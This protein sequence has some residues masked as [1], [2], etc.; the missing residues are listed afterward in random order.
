VVAA[1]ASGGGGGGSSS[2]SSSNN[3]SESVLHVSLDRP[4]FDFAVGV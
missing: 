1:A 4:T 3:L 2:S